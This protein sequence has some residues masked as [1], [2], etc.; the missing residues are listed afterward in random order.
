M[1]YN[2]M[3]NAELKIAIIEMENEYEALKNKIKQS[4]ERMKI[5]DEKYSKAKDVL[6]KRTRGII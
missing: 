5:L 6:N 1:D 2:I 3:S 4:M